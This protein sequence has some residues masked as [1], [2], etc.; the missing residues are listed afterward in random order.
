MKALGLDGAL[1]E[2]KRRGE[3]GVDTG[4]KI[5]PDGWWSRYIR[6]GGNVV[7]SSG[8]LPAPVEYVPPATVIQATTFVSTLADVLRDI[9]DRRAGGDLAERKFR[10]TLHRLALF[11][12]EDHFQQIT[13]YAGRIDKTGGLG[14][15]F[16]VT[17]GIVS[18][19][20]R[21]G[22]LVVAQKTDDAQFAK[23][24]RL[25]QFNTIDARAIEPYVDALVAC[26]FFAPQVENRNGDYVSMVL[27]ADSAQAD[28]FND[29]VLRIISATCTGFVN[30][31][32]RL[33]SEGAL[34]NVSNEY[35]GYAVHPATATIALVGKLKALGVSFD[36][37]N[38]GAYKKNLTFKTVKTLDVEIGTARKWLDGLS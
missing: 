29:E 38:F 5:Y 36:N 35:Q 18:L 26:P 25:T 24:W 31:L 37:A 3:S 27:F 20:C 13:S 23:V 19:A 16:P 32:D 12:G 17:G 34:V 14:R 6:P 10:I 9:G 8:R 30:N 7:D 21:T 1:D 15:I 2:L 33:C 4:S 22:S 11:N 28:F